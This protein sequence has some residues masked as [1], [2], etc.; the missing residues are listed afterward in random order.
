MEPYN[1]SVTEHPSEEDLESYALGHLPESELESL[2]I[3]LF[4]CPQCQDAL[5]E[6]ETFALSIREGLRTFSPP[7]PQ[8]A[9]WREWFQPRPLL[10]FTGA[11]AA[12]AVAVTVSQPPPSLGT[13]AAVVLRAERGGAAGP[14]STAPAHAPLSL[15]LQSD[16]GTLVNG[17]RVQIVD[18]AGRTAWAGAYERHPI[19][20]RT[21]LGAGHYWVRLYD[22]ERRLLQEYGLRLQ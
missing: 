13:P 9:R 11:L 2:E 22:A 8:P 6:A 14:W 21:P 20:L 10:A 16:P 12:L 18:A 4:V 17:A 3:H 19:E 1:L 15:S 7:Q 5:E